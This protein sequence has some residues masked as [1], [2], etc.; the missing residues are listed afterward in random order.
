MQTSTLARTKGSN[1]CA[2][3]RKEIDSFLLD[4]YMKA[5]GMLP[6]KLLC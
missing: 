2:K 6:Q 5:A 1:R 4:I 3:K